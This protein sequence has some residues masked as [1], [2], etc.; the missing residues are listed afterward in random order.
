MT[1]EKIIQLV[2]K[3]RESARHNIEK[4]S[5]EI[6]DKIS[7]VEKMLNSDQATI[8]VLGELQSSVTTYE[9]SV[10]AYARL[11]TILQSCGHFE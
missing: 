8:N 11:T 4:S 3:E 5:K 6:L 7:T 10:G 2:V 1:K 9:A